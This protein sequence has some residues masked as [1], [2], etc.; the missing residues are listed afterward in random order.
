MG[1]REASM[2]AAQLEGVDLDAPRAKRHKTTS[3]PVA[4]KEETTVTNGMN[5]EDAPVAE[6]KEDLEVVKEKGLQLWQAIKDAVNK[7]CVIYSLFR[8]QRV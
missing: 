2:F 5:G 3:S 4:V 1:K 7:E 6:M 8:L